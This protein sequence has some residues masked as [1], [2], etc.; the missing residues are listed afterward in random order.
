VQ[1]AFVPA[2]KLEVCPSVPIKDKDHW[3]CFMNEH[4]IPELTARHGYRLQDNFH[5]WPPYIAAHGIDPESVLGPDHTH[6]GDPIGNDVM[7]QLT[8]PH[9]CYNNDSSASR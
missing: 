8:I 9:L 4:V 3:R 2:N 6:L 1:T 5:Q 7:F